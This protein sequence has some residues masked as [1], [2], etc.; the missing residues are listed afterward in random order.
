[1][2]YT[3]ID[4]NKL[5]KN[6]PSPCLIFV[7]G[8]NLAYGLDSKTIK[9]SLNINPIN[10]G[11]HANIGLKYMLANTLQYIK[12]GDIVVLSS[13]YQQFYGNLAN[14]EGELLSLVTDI[15][16]QSRKLLDYQQVFTLV[17]LLPE[18]AQSKLRP[19]L[20]FYKFPKNE[21]VGRY[22]RAAFNTY[23]DATAHWKLPGENPKPY[24]AIQESFNLDA[25]QALLNFRNEVYQKKAKLYVTFPGY[26]YSSYQKSVAQI[27]QVKEVLINNHFLLISSPEEYIIPD[28]LIFDT[29]YHLTKKGVDYRTKHLIQ[30]LKK[31][32]KR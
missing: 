27:K 25:L 5:L 17:K 3:Q 2:L 22:D 6:T 26:Q 10:T 13:E 31:V 30:D 1:M 20:L 14:G 19:I 9:D 11:V 28:S 12:P 32:V 4:K 8:S 16:P 24:P 15:V 21:G 29:P 7:G 23:G 18:Y